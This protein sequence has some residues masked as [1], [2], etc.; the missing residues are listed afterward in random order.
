MSVRTIDHGWEKFKREM[1]KIKGAHTKVGVQDG[2]LHLGEQTRDSKGRF[3]ERKK[4]DLALIAAAN[5]FGT[6]DGRI[7]ERSFLRSTFDEQLNNIVKLKDKLFTMLVNQQIGSV[8]ALA[9]LG[10]F[11]QDKVKK[12][13]NSNVPPPN[14]PSTIAAKGSS[15]TLI[16]SG[17]LLQSIQHTEYLK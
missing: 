15:K 12:K 5:E 1:A 16:D 2:A 10:Q 9:L 17:Q 6:R 7:P 13:I 11:F 8:Q 4:A 3:G 14:A